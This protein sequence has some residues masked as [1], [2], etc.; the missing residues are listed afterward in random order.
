MT[1]L[2]NLTKRRSA[3]FEA[4]VDLFLNAIWGLSLPDQIQYNVRN[5]LDYTKLSL[6]QQ[7]ELSKFLNLIS[8]SLKQKVIVFIFSDVLKS[9]SIFKDYFDEMF[10]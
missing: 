1:V 9:N 5:Y 10:A 2:M 8:P 4:K 6:E 7:D 3:I